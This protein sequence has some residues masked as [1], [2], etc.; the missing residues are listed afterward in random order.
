MQ[1]KTHYVVLGLLVGLLIFSAGCTGI[2]SDD[3]STRDILLV[4]QDETDHAVVVEIFDDS[5]LVYSDGRTIDA[6]S[7]LDMAQFNRTGEYKVRVSVN[8]DSTTIRHTFEFE[9]HPVHITNIGINNEGD[10]TIE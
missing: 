7:D 3:D 4:N 5:R 1:D 10:V 2:L 8:G 6:E 9:D